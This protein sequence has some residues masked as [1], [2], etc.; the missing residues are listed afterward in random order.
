MVP[1]LKAFMGIWIFMGFVKKPA[2]RDYWSLGL[3][4]GEFSIITDTF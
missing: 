2:I 1:K 4:E 3:I